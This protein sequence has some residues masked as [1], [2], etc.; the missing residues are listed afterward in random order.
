MFKAHFKYLLIFVLSTFTLL[1]YSKEYLKP[2]EAF[3]IRGQL[4]Q[5]GLEITFDNSKGYYIYQDS[6][7]VSTKQD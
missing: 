1:S 2:E 5:E 7:Q 4:T 3:K 6:I